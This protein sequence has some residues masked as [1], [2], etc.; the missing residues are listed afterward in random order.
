MSNH[1]PE[2]GRYAIRIPSMRITL[3]QS[4]SESF[5][6]TQQFAAFGIGTNGMDNGVREFALC[7]ILTESL[8]CRVLLDIEKETCLLDMEHTGGERKISPLICQ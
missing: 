4:T 5:L 1:V 3:L 2:R 8:V 6:F 7:Q